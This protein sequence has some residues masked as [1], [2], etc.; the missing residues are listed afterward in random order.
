[1]TLK[2]KTAAYFRLCLFLLIYSCI[3]PTLPPAADCQGVIG[4][5]AVKDDCNHCTGGTTGVTFNYLLGCDSSCLGTQFDCDSTCGG[6]AKRDCNNDCNGTAYLAYSC[7]D[8]SGNGL[9][10]ITTRQL[11]CLPES[12]T[13]NCAAGTSSCAFVDCSV[14]SMYQNTVINCAGNLPEDCDLI[15]NTCVD[16]NGYLGDS[17]CDFL[18]TNCSE[19]NYDGGDCNLVDCTG[20]HFSE[21]LCIRLFD[22][23][24]TEEPNPWLGDGFCD[25]GDNDLKLN[26]NCAEWNFD[27]GDCTSN[28]RMIPTRNT[29]KWRK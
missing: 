14:D 5:S 19:F 8:T 26:L 28:S 16:Y 18:D 17:E 25:E 13:G 10:D 15:S 4:G 29:Q 21:E 11:S 27:N 20:I 23:G 7:S 1:M 6:T 2:K 9:L 24:C 22:G 12:E 3:E